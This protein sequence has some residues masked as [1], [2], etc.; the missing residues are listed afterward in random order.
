[1][2]GLA[3]V[4]AIFVILLGAAAATAASTAPAITVTPHSVAFDSMFT[5]SFVTP[6]AAPTRGYDVRLRA[7]VATSPDHTCV[8]HLD[9]YNPKPV[10]AHSPLRFA[11]VPREAQGL[12]A[13]T[14]T[15]DVRRDGSD[16]I[17]GGRFT[18]HS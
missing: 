9:F 4:T 17:T 13:G 5:I 7:T 16:V 14:W 3:A 18:L 2:K 10:V 6:A 15:V 11:Y 8:A 12:C 1:V